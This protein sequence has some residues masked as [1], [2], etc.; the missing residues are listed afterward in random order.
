MPDLSHLTQ[1]IYTRLVGYGPL[2]ADLPTFVNLPAVFS[3]FIV[4]PQAP[5]PRVVIAA[6]SLTDRSQ[7]DVSALIR[8]VNR[9]VFVYA[10]RSPSG[11]SS[12]NPLE[13]MAENVRSALHLYLLPLAGWNCI[14][15][16]ASGPRNAPTDET[17]AGRVIT[18]R[19]QFSQT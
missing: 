12:E 5:L 1:A 13:R 17:V 4:P 6:E 14:L 7:D 15:A 18:V 16:Q 8:E 3:G 19:Y 9:D 10:S 2:I 11:T